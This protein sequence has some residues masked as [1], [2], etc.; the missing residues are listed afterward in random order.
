MWDAC[1]GQL[2]D[3]NKYRHLRGLLRQAGRGNLLHDW[4]LRL[5]IPMIATGEGTNS[6]SEFAQ[7]HLKVAYD[8]MDPITSHMML[9]QKWF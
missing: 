4:V 9:L 5:H 3:S 6:E 1:L 2:L 8:V 7:L